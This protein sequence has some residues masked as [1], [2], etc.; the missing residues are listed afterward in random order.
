MKKSLFLAIF[1]LTAAL[2]ADVYP[3]SSINSGRDALNNPDSSAVNS[4]QNINRDSSYYQNQPSGQGA[5]YQQTNPNLY[6]QDPS[7]LQYRNPSI[8]PSTSPSLN[9]SG[10]I[11]PGGH[12]ALPN[13]RNNNTSYDQT[14]NRGDFRDNRSDNRYL[15]IQM[16][17]DDADRDNLQMYK[18]SNPSGAMAR[19]GAPAQVISDVEIQRSVKDQLTGNWVTKNYDL[20]EVRVSNGDVVLLGIVDTTDDKRTIEDR[21]KK[22]A[23]VRNV[24]NQIQAK[25]PSADDRK[26][27]FGSNAAT[28][29]ASDA[30]LKKDIQGRLTGNWFAKNYPGVQVDVNNG[31]VVLK[32]SVDSVQDKQYIEKEIKTIR[33]V[34]NLDN[35]IFVRGN[36]SKA[37]ANAPGSSKY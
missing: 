4:T 8:L 5:Y 9:T 36:E 7:N 23:G 6:N 27:T 13:N 17:G 24:I 35:Q 22:I 1:S 37:D 18:Q 16:S 31:N 33:G 28:P 20:V 10:E 19:D 32:G 14:M 30:D 15:E 21:V 34:R 26:T 11:V 12:S 25:N 2:N 29:I 3:G